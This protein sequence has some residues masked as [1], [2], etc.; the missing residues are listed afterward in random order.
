MK[1]FLRILAIVAALSLCVTA[2]GMVTRI[3]KTRM[4]KYYKVY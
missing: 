1:A 2:A 3:F 4:T